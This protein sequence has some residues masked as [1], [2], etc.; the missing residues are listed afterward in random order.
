MNRGTEQSS[1]TDCDREPVHLIGAIQGFGTLI[2]VNGDWIVA[3]LAD[4]AQ[5]ILCAECTLE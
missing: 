4:N 1:L 5:E 2:A 3:H